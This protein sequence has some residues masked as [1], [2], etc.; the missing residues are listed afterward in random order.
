MGLSAPVPEENQYPVSFPEAGKHISK[1][2][3][4]GGKQAATTEN[5]LE[6]G[7]TLPIQT[8]D[9][10]NIKEEE[11]SVLALEKLFQERF[12]TLL[13]LHF[14]DRFETI[15]GEIAMMTRKMSTSEDEAEENTEAK[16]FLQF[17]QIPLREGSGVTYLHFSYVLLI[18]QEIIP[19]LQDLLKKTQG[20]PQEWEER[21]TGVYEEMI[22]SD[23]AWPTTEDFINYAYTIFI[24]R[25]KGEWNE[26]EYGALIEE[27]LAE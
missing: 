21:V 17:L 8:P 6:N 25:K 14:A 10:Q 27:I 24:A 18:K 5:T 1:Q 19:L 12:G 20:N 15:A 16:E 4:K 26:A 23:P 9:E 22:H 3:K 13:K 11:L 7:D 2:K